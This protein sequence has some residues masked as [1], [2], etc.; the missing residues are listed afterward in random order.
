MSKAIRVLKTAVVSRPIPAATPIA[1]VTHIL[2]AVVSPRV[3]TSLFPIM[4]APVPRNPTPA[5]RPCNIRLRSA[6][7]APACWGMRTNSAAPMATIMCVRTPALLPCCSRSYPNRP[8]RV[9]ATRRRS[10]IRVTC[11]ASGTSE[12]SDS[13]V[14]HISCHISIVLVVTSRFSVLHLGS[15]QGRT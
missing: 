12:N 8:P 1:A 4:M 3:S 6:L 13:T 15:S 11:S 5:I 9:A 14:F 2:A 10:V 7:D